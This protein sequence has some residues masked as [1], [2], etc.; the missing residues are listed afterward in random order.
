MGLN[1]Q[2]PL[3]PG[4]TVKL[5]FHGGVIGDW[6]MTEQLAAEPLHHGPCPQRQMVLCPKRQPLAAA[7][8]VSHGE[9][10]PS[11]SSSSSSLRSLAMRGR[12]RLA[13]A[14]MAM[15]AIGVV[16]NRLIR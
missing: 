7:F 4:T 13:K 3:T 8:L 11:H 1:G 6:V 10:R 2:A 15:T 16:P 9:W 14:A 12:T 5:S